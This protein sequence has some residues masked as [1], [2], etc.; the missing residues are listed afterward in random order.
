[1]PGQRFY[2]SFVLNIYTSLYGELITYFGWTMIMLTYVAI[3][4][5]LSRSSWYYWTVFDGFESSPNRLG[6]IKYKVFYRIRMIL[7]GSKQYGCNT[8]VFDSLYLCQIRR[9][10]TLLREGS[11]FT[12][13]KILDPVVLGQCSSIDMVHIKWTISYGQYQSSK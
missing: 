13:T 3:H 12:N 5:V 6:E 1:M 4:S 7:Y 10:N 8:V 2:Q 9:T 11:I